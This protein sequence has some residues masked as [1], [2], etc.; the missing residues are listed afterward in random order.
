VV[1]HGLVGIAMQKI[2]HH[3]LKKLVP[4]LD[5]TSCRENAKLLEKIDRERESF[6]SI[7]DREREWS[8]K[9]SVSFRER[10]ASFFNSKSIKAAAA[11]A[12]KRFNEQQLET[13]QLLIDLAARAYELEKGRRPGTI[14]DL[15]PEYLKAPPTDPISGTNMVYR[16]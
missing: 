10:L 15:V 2:N 3:N 11:K 7:K 5:A 14:T 4:R 16:L 6:E 1:I 13:R 9:A 8:R 12:E